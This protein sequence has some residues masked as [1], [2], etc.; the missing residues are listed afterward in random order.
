[1]LEGRRYPPAGPPG[2]AVQFALRKADGSGQGRAGAPR[3][4]WFRQKRWLTLGE[5]FGRALWK[6]PTGTPSSRLIASQDLP[7]SFQL[8]EPVPPEDAPGRPQCLPAACAFFTP[9]TT[10]STIISR[11]SSLKADLIEIMNRPI[12]E[13]SSAL[14]THAVGH[15]AAPAVQAEHQAQ[16]ELAAGGFREPVARRAVALG[17]ETPVFTD[18]ST[19]SLRAAA[20]AKS[21]ARK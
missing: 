7:A 13:L 6:V 10:L 20:A 15:R 9:A 11:S 2:Q 4:C 17:A 5:P 21:G 18:S 19:T 16:I 3:A 12:S 14:R 8:Q 1:M